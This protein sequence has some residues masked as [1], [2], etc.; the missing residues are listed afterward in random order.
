MRLAYG[1]DIVKKLWVD[2]QVVLGRENRQ[3][4]EQMVRGRYAIGIGAVTDNILSEFLAQG[5]GKNLKHLELDNVEQVSGG[6]DV[7][8]MVNRAPHPNAAKLF[9]NWLLTKEGSTIW[10]KYAETNSRRTDVPPFDP[11]QQPTPGKKYIQLDTDELAPE[12]GKTQ[13]IAQKVLTS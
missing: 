5:L 12:L 9:I 6:G 4:T 11:A 2:Q 3:M 1:D 10:S 13:E 7:V 8:Q